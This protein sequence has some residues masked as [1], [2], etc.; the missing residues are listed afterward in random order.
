M[1]IY[2]AAGYTGK[3]IAERA[4]ELGL[5]FEIAGRGED[6]IIEV[7]HELS[8]PYHIFTVDDENAWKKALSDKHVLIN[9]AGPFT[10]TAKSAIEACL[11]AKVHYLDISAE[12][13]T[14][15]LAE[16]LDDRAKEA[17]IQLISGA[18]LFVSYDAL[19]VHLSQLVDEPQKL[20]M[21]FQHYGGFS[22][23][24]V[25]SSKNIADLGILVRRNDEI[26]K[27]KDAQPK[28]FS[29]GKEDIECI[30][31]PLGGIILSYKSTDIPNIEEYFSLKLPALSQSELDPNNLPDGPTKEERAAGRN[32]ISGEIVGKDGKIVRAMIDAPSGYTLTPIS[33]VAVANRILNNDFKTGFQSPGS[34]YGSGILNDLPDTYVIN[35]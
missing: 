21:G 30:P 12:M 23:G 5:D 20:S 17:N 35:L 32:A 13:E 8:V 33:A 6:S 3:I 19:A 11:K 18:G 27:D 28:T 4:K 14:Y 34:A 16:S 24:S 26:Q 22:K 9:A 15:Q 29:F 7:A 2:G 25:L 1:L 31:T 10:N